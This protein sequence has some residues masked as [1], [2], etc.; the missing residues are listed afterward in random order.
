MKCIQNIFI[1]VP[2][3]LILHEDNIIQDYTLDEEKS[4]QMTSY[5]E[6]PFSG[7]GA[8]GVLNP[9]TMKLVMRNKVQLLMDFCLI[10]PINFQLIIY[11]KT[12]LKSGNGC[13]TLVLMPNLKLKS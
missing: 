1:A 11:K 6:F 3:F 5:P 4:P 10:I 12:R 8:C 2:H 9:S 13:L 7:L